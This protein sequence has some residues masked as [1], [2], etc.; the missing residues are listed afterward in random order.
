VIVL[1]AGSACYSW[2]LPPPRRLDGLRLR[3]SSQKDCARLQRSFV[4][5]IVLTPRG[6]RRAT[7]VERVI[8]LPHLMVGSC[9]ALWESSV[10][11]TD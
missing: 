7:L 8:E 5:E 3:R 9:G 6:S 4:R 2:R 10:V 1:Q 11:D